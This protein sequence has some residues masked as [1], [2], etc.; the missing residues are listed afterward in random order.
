[1]HTMNQKFLVIGGSGFIGKSLVSHLIKNRNAVRVLSPSADKHIWDK[2][3][4]PIV[5][6]I[7]NNDLITEQVRWADIVI[8][9][10]TKYIDG[11]G[12]AA[13]ASA[14]L[15]SDATKLKPVRLS[16]DI[17]VQHALRDELLKG[18]EHYKAKAGGG[19]VIDVTTGE[20]IALASLPDFDPNNP[21]DALDPEKINRIVVGTYEMGSTFK[22]L[23]TAMA[24]DSGKITINSTN[25]RRTNRAIYD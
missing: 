24:L 1:M 11:Q 15:A 6:S 16:I 5:G 14:G 13:L 20:V 19:M 21:K 4:E 22:A 8:H 9:S 7:E 10:A 3:I 25:G 17:R 23:T 12:L 18:I 2:G